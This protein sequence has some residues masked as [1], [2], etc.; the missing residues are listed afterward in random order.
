MFDLVR[1]SDVARYKVGD[2][3]ETIKESG[4][5]HVL[6]S[7]DMGVHTGI[8]GIFSITQVSRQIGQKIEFSNR[9]NT[10]AELEHALLANA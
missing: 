6:V 9:A 4:R 8:R 1:I 2:I 3:V 5:H 10:F 7:E